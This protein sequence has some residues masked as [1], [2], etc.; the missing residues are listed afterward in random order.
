M[1]VLELMPE[2]VPWDASTSAKARERFRETGA[3]KGGE[4]TGR[5]LNW[6]LGGGFEGQVQLQPLVGNQF[7]HQAQQQSGDEIK[8]NGMLKI[9]VLK[10]LMTV[11]FF[12]FE[13]D[14]FYLY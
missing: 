1:P 3:P 4:E 8:L 9:A 13:T 12:V 6:Q 10:M 11:F 2:S 14:V 5:G 7:H